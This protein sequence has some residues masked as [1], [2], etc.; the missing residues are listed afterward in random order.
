MLKKNKRFIFRKNLYINVLILIVCILIPVLF[1]RLTSETPKHR[2]IHIENFRYGKNPSAIYCNRGDTLHLTFSSKDT[3][4]SFFLE[5]FDLDVKVEPVNNTVLVF[6]AS[7]PSYPPEIKD[8][9][10]LVAKHPGILG[11]I[12]SKSNYRCH[13]WC[14][15]MHAFEHGKIVIYPNYLLVTGL[16]IL[17]G[18]YVIFIRRIIYRQ[19]SGNNRQEKF[20]GHAAPDLLVKFPWLKKIIKRNGFQSFFMIFAFT[21]LY[22]VLLT[23][24]FGTQMSGRN[25]GVL[26]VWTVW[27]FLVV[28]IFTPFGGRLWCL[29]CPLPMVGDFLQRRAITRVREGNTNGFRN[30]FFGLNRKWPDWL[31]N[32]WTRLFLFLVTGTL[33][34]TLVAKPR[35]TG[36][37]VLFLF[38]GATLMAGIW[39]LRAFCRYVCP[40]NTFISLYAKMG[41]LSIRKA[42]YE[43]CASCKPLFCEK[44]SV[45]RMGVSIWS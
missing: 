15:P 39:E 34:T 36:I 26:L 38:I 5:E 6:K 13:V 24:L 42:D 20:A 28:T 22:V 21:I 25:L 43:V 17:F 44:G 31:S 10:V 45:Q 30:R 23:T 29:A 19:I 18:I 16:G 3:G 27:L 2:F 37:A 35:A 8:E 7:D 14:G 41:K 1:L 4:H 32:G 33:S 40:I 12:I 11:S 9:V